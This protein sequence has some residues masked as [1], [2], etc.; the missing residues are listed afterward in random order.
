MELPAPPQFP[1]GGTPP[2]QQAS[3]RASL[4]GAPVMGDN[5]FIPQNITFSS[6]D[7]VL[8]EQLL[9]LDRIKDVA[10]ANMLSHMEKQPIVAER[11]MRNMLHAMNLKI[12]CVQTYAAAAVSASRVAA[13]TDE[14]Q[15]SV[16][17]E[18]FDISPETY[19]A[20]AGAIVSAQRSGGQ[21]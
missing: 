11:Y 13:R 5:T 2:N 3:D 1:V 14:P 6:L 19:D 4:V 8:R 20:I 21:T 17:A 9:E 18:P 15:G 16:R 12:K 10:E 7:P